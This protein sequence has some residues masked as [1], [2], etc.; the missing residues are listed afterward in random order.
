MSEQQWTIG[1]IL[2]WTKQYFEGKGIDSPRLDAEVLLCHVLG[3]DRVY[4]YIN[5]EQPL[6]PEELAAYRELV[7]QRAM[8]RPVA[9]VTG[10]KE[11]MGLTFAVSPA[12]LVPRPDTE[13]LVETALTRLKPVQAPAILDLG[14]GS[15][16]IIVSLLHK[17]PAAQGMAV[18]ISAEALAMARQN[19][20]AH[21]VLDRLDVRQGDLFA[22]AEGMFDAIVSNPPYIDAEDMT[23]LAPEVAYEPRL[24]LAGGADGLDYYRRIVADAG[25]YLSAAG[26]VALEVGLGQA[27][28]VADFASEATGLKTADI[29]KDYAGIE[30]VVVLERR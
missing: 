22:P 21:Q 15:G 12:V 4:L 16:A 14:T 6:Q 2:A 28:L 5:F 24:A 18:D 9:Y 1:A 27:C 11:F 17:L 30:R 8:R 29:I 13:I 26:F 25:R 19:A 10:R 23:N 20:A 7:K 3:K